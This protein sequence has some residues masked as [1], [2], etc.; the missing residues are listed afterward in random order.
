MTAARPGRLAASP[1]CAALMNR[2]FFPRAHRDRFPDALSSRGGVS[3]TCPGSCTRPPLFLGLA[4]YNVPVFDKSLYPEKPHFCPFSSFPMC[5]EPAIRPSLSTF[6]LIKYEQV[7]T[8]AVDLSVSQLPA[9]VWLS[10][11][12]ESWASVLKAP[13]MPL[14]DPVILWPLC[15]ILYFSVKPCPNGGGRW[16][17][18]KWV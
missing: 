11:R 10:R 14:R 13:E 1:L 2:S 17:L 18:K 16:P 4:G 6:N 15:G 3:T 5:T 7:L 12:K 9:W 8:L